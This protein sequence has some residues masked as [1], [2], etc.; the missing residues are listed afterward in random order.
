MRILGVSAFFHDAAACLVED[1]DIVAAAQE[2]RFS[3]VKNDASF[4]S[5][6]IQACL[7]SAG[8]TIDQV[9]MVAFHEKPHLKFERILSNARDCHPQGF[10]AF[11]AAWSKW[12]QRKLWTPSVIR[13]RVVDLSPSEGRKMRWDGR[14]LFPR[15]HQSHAASAFFPS[16]FDSAAILTVDGVGEWATTSLA[17]GAVDARGVPRMRFLSEIRY[18]HSLGLLYSA[19]TRYLG[20]E[21]NEG[22]Y[23]M[24]GLAPYGN[25]RY[26]D[27]ILDRLIKVHDDAS[28]S[29]NLDLFTYQ[30]SME[31]FGKP[32]CDLFGMPMRAAESPILDAHMDIAA[33]IQAVTE[34][35]FLGLAHRVYELTGEKRLCLAGGVALNCVANGL[36]QRSGPFDDVWVQPAAGDAG[37]ALGAA[38]F[39]WHQVLGERRPTGAGAGGGAGRAH[40]KAA[41]LGPAYGPDRCRQALDAAGVTYREVPEADLAEASAGMLSDGLILGWFQGRMEFGPRALGCR[42]I[43]ADPRSAD[44]QRQLNLRV[45]FRESFRPLAP[46]VLRE[47][48]ADWFDL[49]GRAGS[50]LGSADGGYDSPYMLLVA[51]V[52]KERW[53]D[54]DPA[55]EPAGTARIDVAR[56]EIPS[57]THVDHSARVQT[58][59]ADDNPLLH[60]L[61]SAFDR[62]TQVPV[63]V[64]TSF[65]VRGEPIVCTPE[66]AVRCFLSTRIDVLVLGNLVAEKSAQAPGVAAEMTH[67]PAPPLAP[68]D[69]N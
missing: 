52:A 68:V 26:A 67:A 3:R 8:I 16:P 28:F 4:P 9:D 7:E 39:A 55:S 57:C 5:Q 38:L 11:A 58:V 33:S 46:C 65:N 18:P 62:R 29:L 61:I 34:Q 60:A 69:W 36:V 37:G 20:F 44:M 41:M 40:M 17:H 50:I 49:Q 43:L 19:F 35:V 56:S 23:K 32:F 63:L 14:V 42:S 53:V 15:H 22:E 27:L 2:E 12:T 54:V 1:G 10:D 48:V 21:V 31:M 64:N 13:Q 30:H 45:K 51:P 6:A 59:A 25:P 24:M 47:R 66:D